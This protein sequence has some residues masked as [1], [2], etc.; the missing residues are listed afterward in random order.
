[1]DPVGRSLVDG[2]ERGPDMATR[3]QRV[4]VDPG[5]DLGPVWAAAFFFFLFFYLINRG[6]HLDHLG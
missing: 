4:A 6:G 2:D 1:M 3:P 5:L